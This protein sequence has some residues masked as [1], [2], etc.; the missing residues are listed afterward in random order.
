MRTL[1]EQIADRCRHFNGIQNDCCK[2]GVRYRSVEVPD[3]RP[4]RLPCFKA[5][6]FRRV[7]EPEIPLPDCAA[8]S[9]LTADE[10]EAEAAE[11]EASIRAFLEKTAAGICAVCNGSLEPRRQ[12]SRC[13]YGACGHRIGQ[14][15]L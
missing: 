11:H 3:A 5:D 6:A 15:T 9:F 2:A 12:V 14:G 10:V 1:R 13:I 7:G 4:I 8:R